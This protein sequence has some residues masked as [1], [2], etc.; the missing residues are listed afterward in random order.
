MLGI[1]HACRHGTPPDRAPGADGRRKIGQSPAFVPGG[2]ARLAR[3][4]V[5]QTG[6]TQG[7]EVRGSMSDGLLVLLPHN[8]GD[9]VMALQAIRRVKASY[10]GL[11][12]DYVVSE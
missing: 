7:A 2:A 12:V 10:P 6:N 8:P 4:P 11:P 5:G 1:C 9:V 3:E